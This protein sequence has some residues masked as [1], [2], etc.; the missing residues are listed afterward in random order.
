[1]SMECVSFKS[2]TLQTMTL[3]LLF[4]GWCTCTMGWFFQTEVLSRCESL[5][6]RVS[7]PC[8]SGTDIQEEALQVYFDMKPN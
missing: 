4:S 3:E 6:G 8:V 2:K 1:M 5:Y 7:R